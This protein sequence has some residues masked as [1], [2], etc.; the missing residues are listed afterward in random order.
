MG[1][2]KSMTKSLLI[3]GGIAGG[4]SSGFCVS[5]SCYGGAEDVIV[6]RPLSSLSVAVRGV[7]GDTHF[8]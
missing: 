2:I 7:Q 4:V 3:N 1:V 8:I 6:I 5:A